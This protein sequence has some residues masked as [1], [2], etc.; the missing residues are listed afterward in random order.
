MKNIETESA[1]YVFFF[2]H[3]E[4][5]SHIN[6]NFSG[7]Q[8]DAKLCVPAIIDLKPPHKIFLDLECIVNYCRPQILSR[9][10]SISEKDDMVIDSL[11]A[12][13]NH[14]SLHKVIFE[15]PEISYQLQKNLYIL[16]KIDYQRM[17]YILSL[18]ER[19]L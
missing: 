6:A 8:L 13:I 14:E 18:M 1:I 3:D 9:H 4:F 17:E 2:Q 12:N 7:Y 19:D 15:I 16:K 11:I 5:V 10:L